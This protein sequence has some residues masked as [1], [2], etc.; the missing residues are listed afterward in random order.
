MHADSPEA[1][2]RG[3]AAAH[4]HVSSVAND[5]VKLLKAL[6][7]KKTRAETGLFLAEGARH[8][9]EALKHGW[10]PAYAFAGREALERPK[11]AELMGR[12]KSAG[13]RTLSGSD[14][15]MAAIARKDNPQTVVAAFHQ[16]LTPLSEFPATGPR[17]FVALYEVRDPGNLGTVVRTADAAGVDG[18]IL[19]G[20]T[21]DPFSVEAVRAT[22]GS[23]FAMRLAEAEFAAFDAWRR[24]I[25]AHI[26]AASMHGDHRH[27]EA[28]W[29]ERSIVLMGN[30]QSGLPQDVEAACDELVRIPMSGSADS[31]NLA[32][33]ASVMIYE[34]WRAGGYKG[35]DR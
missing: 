5:T 22:M 15:V 13:A 34:C 2:S 4:E 9:E 33:A 18:V 32:S 35:A 8:A 17:R 23:L 30:E 19:V 16:K 7:S 26:V 12:L 14:K 21:C 11:T 10:K 27:D 24:K 20:K 6:A 3:P 1:R 28:R 29:S 25:G 31:L